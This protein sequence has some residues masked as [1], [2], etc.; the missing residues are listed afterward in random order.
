MSEVAVSIRQSQP[1]RWRVPLTTWRYQGG[2]RDGRIDLLRGYAGFA[3]IVDHIGR[4][5]GAGS[6]LFAVTGGNRFFVSAA[7]AF[8]LISGVVMGIVYGG[9]IRKDGAAALLHKSARR[10]GMLYLSSVSL[11]LIL[12]G[13]ATIFGLHWAPDLSHTSI[14]AWLAGVLTLHRAFYLTDVLLLYTVLVLAAGPVLVALHRGHTRAVLAG[15]WGLWALWQLSPENAQVPW[16]MVGAFAFP[17][18]AWQ[19]V[20][21]NGIVVGFHR[22]ALAEKLRRIPMTLALA[23]SGMMAAALLALWLVALS[24]FAVQQRSGV[25]ASL[26]LDKDNVA[27]GRVL[28]MAVFSVF[29]Y[30]LVTLAWTPVRNL[31]GRLLLP[32]GEKALFAYVAHLFIVAL[33]DAARIGD[34]VRT[35]ATTLAMTAVQV[36]G[37]AVVWWLIRRFPNGGSDM[38]RALRTLAGSS[39]RPAAHRTLQT[40]SVGESKRVE[41]RRNG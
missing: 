33:V 3:M 6:L 38:L 41:T 1:R 39:R 24:P 12:A 17:I 32:L 19:L 15:T 21:M 28:T 5:G 35:P 31:T 18:P 16:S 34:G 7:E 25:L 11:T 9:I 40:A 10:A 4:S 20:F 36:A 29:S 23:V 2:K 14:A 22:Q 27:A 13:L 8:V 26:L 30:A 37:V